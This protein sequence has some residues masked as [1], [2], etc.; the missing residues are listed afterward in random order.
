MYSCN[1]TIYET[2]GHIS[3]C[4]VGDLSGKNGLM[5]VVDRNE[6]LYFSGSFENDPNGPITSNYFGSNAIW[7]SIVFHKPIP[8]YDAFYC[9]LLIPQYISYPNVTVIPTIL[10]SPRPTY[11]IAPGEIFALTFTALLVSSYVSFMIYSYFMKKSGRMEDV[12]RVGRP[13]SMRGYGHGKITHTTAG[14]TVNESGKGLL[15]GGSL[16]EV[17]RPFN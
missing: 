13:I 2:N 4:E 7:K 14:A 16:T 17:Y 10:S 12:T 5:H 9:S 11:T 8:P 15:H 3:Q 1:R 6:G